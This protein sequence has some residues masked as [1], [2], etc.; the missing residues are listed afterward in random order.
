MVTVLFTPKFVKKGNPSIE[1]SLFFTG[2]YTD[3]QIKIRPHLWTPPTDVYEMAEE[4]IVRIEIPGVEERNLVVNIDQN[5]LVVSGSR[6][7]LLE[8]CIFHQMEIQFGEFSAEIEL[9]DL[10]E[11]DRVTVDYQNGFLTIVL[12]KA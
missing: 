8:P 1:N 9:P 10:V 11:I 3:W 5:R 12:P 2:R 4:F 7:N 6:K